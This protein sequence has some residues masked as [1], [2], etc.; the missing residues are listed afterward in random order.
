MAVDTLHR[1]GSAP[2]RMTIKIHPPWWRT[3]PAYLSAAVLGCAFLILLSRWRD[4]YLLQRQHQLEALVRERTREIEQAR[5]V[6]FKQATYDALTGLLN[7]SAVLERLRVAM[8]GARNA[9]APLALALLD[10]DHFKKINDVFGHLGGDA[11]LAE[12][13]RRLTASTREGVDAGRYGG[14]ELLLVLP[15]LKE[16]MF[17][18]IET[19]RD[20]VFAAPFQFDSHSIG[21]TC[22]MGVTWMH[23]GDDVTSMIR[24]ADA[25]LYAAKRDGRDRIVFD[26][27]LS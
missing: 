3:W 9:G 15:G 25:A 7:R 14:E 23:P 5:L 4:R 13:G 1:L 21:I 10:L 22:S 19:L 6:L 20:A 27:P 18:R 12:V 2:A 16:G 11:V 8:E 17:E 26:P 24:R